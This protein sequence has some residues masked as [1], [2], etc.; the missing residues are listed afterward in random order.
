MTHFY[1]VSKIV[2]LLFTSV[3]VAMKNQ[4]RKQ[5]FVRHVKECVMQIMNLKK[6][7]FKD[8]NYQENVF[9]KFVIQKD[10]D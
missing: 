8:L 9:A 1:I 7:V 4:K 6:E 3:R 5:W 2:T 10:H